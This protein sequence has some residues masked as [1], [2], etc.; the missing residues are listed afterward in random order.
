M[1]PC[2]FLLQLPLP[3][4]HKT[5]PTIYGTK[6][7]QSGVRI[8]VLYSFLLLNFVFFC[9]VSVLVN[10]TLLICPLILSHINAAWFPHALL[11]GP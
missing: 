5:E 8:R 2:F 1:I 7:F 6:F 9:T 3:K 10:L 11:H 4:I